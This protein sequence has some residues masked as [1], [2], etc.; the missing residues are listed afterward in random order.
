MN[1]DLE[2]L[3]KEGKKAGTINRQM[4]RRTDGHEE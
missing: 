3:I 4:E 2:A 1:T